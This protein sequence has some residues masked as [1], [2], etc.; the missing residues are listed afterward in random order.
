M[1]TKFIMINTIIATLVIATFG[2]FSISRYHE[3]EVLE[4]NENIEKCMKTFK[5]F[6][7]SKGEFKVVD[8][9]L[10]AGNYLINGN[11]EIPDKVQE[12]FGGVATVFMGDIRVSTN[13]LNAEKNRAVGTRLIGPAYNSVFK[14]RQSYRGEA[15]ILGLPYFTAYDLIMDSKGQIIGVLFVGIK[16]SEFLAG[17]EFFEMQQ[18]LMLSAFIAVFSILMVWLGCLTKK[19]ELTKT[20]HLKF[21][22]TLIDTIPLPIFYK[23]FAGRYLGCNNAFESCVQQSREELAGKTV[24]ELWSREQAEFYEQKDLALFQKPGKQ[25]FETSIKLADGS[26]HDVIFN[27]A[28]FQAND[29]SLGGLVGAILDITERKRVES[30]LMFQNILLTTQQESSID[31]ILVVAENNRILFYNRRLVELMAI[32]P[33]ILDT[34]DDHSFFEFFHGQVIDPDIFVG[35][36]NYLYL[37]PQETCR[38]EVTLRTG[39]IL[40]CYSAPLNR[41]D[42]YYYGRFW[43]FRDVTE[44]KAAEEK[45]QSAYQQMLNIVEFLPDATFVVD[46]EKRVIAWNRAMEKMTGLEKTEIVGKGDFEYAI[47]FYGVRR[48]ILIDLLDADDSTLAPLYSFIRKEDKT[49]SAQVFLPALDNRKGRYVSS[50]ASPLFDDHGR[51]IG[52]IQSIRDLTEIKRVEEEKTWLEVQLQHSRMMQTVMV[53]LGHDLKTPLTPLITLLPIIS[54][55]LSDRSLQRMVDICLK[56]AHQ[57]SELLEK[58]IDVSSLTSIITA[59]K[60]EN[61]VLDSTL[62]VLLSQSFGNLTYK[63]TIAPDI[64]V[65]A[66]PLQ[67]KQV[68]TNI[69]SNAIRYSHEDGVVY[70]TA[71]QTETSVTVSVRDN[72]IGLAPQHLEQIFDEFFKV[73]ESRHDLASV[74]LGLSI[75]KRIIHNH[76]G[77]IWA[78]SPGIGQGT[79][80]LFTLPRIRL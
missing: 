11:F 26:Q 16:K 19:I 44:R 33:H 9:K 39:M 61:M 80:I 67:L 7:I 14:E 20:N 54:K 69:I 64:V 17:Y 40:D 29:G 13:V 37:H 59:D 15:L 71:D 30:E 60:L 78:E 79:T 42:G 74:G 65:Q 56:N 22:Q 53:Q 62:D 12:I 35:K 49:I 28:T 73:D 50:T 75:C 34:N 23:D 25:I 77:R 76:K 24:H 43:T 8:N 68:F 45:I 21:L 52:S 1:T 3:R 2:F 32:P 48:P 57:I 38:N 72:G 46:L 4:G 36:T 6:F 63:K 41:A 51:H 18:I 27:K 55:C 31:G 58:T 70:I 10:M 47:P 5:E 66:E